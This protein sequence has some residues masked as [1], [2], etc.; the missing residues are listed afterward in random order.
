MSKLDEY[1]EKH[2]SPKTLEE[3]CNERDAL[4]SKGYYDS[5][6]DTNLEYAKFLNDIKEKYNDK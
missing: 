2:F 5:N 3:S 6:P 4:Y 1:L